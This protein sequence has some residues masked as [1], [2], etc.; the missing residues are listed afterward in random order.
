MGTTDS[1]YEFR[2]SD[3]QI[4]AMRDICA[5]PLGL[6]KHRKTTSLGK[7]LLVGLPNGEG[8]SSLLL[9]AT[10]A[11]V[12]V[13]RRLE[14]QGARWPAFRVTVDAAALSNAVRETIR[15][16]KESDRAG[17]PLPADLRVA[18]PTTRPEIEIRPNLYTEAKLEAEPAEWPNLDPENPTSFSSSAPGYPAWEPIVLKHLDG[19]RV[20]IDGAR[21]D[22]R[23]AAA[24]SKAAERFVVS[25]NPDVLA[26]AAKALGVAKD[27]GLVFEMVGGLDPALIAREEDPPGTFSFGLVMPRRSD[28]VRRVGFVGRVL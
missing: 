12:L 14:L 24:V 6:E 3:D 19:K 22:Q 8:R 15:V 13:V 7:V 16:R 1:V 25:W 26:T 2:L 28:K 20:P 9:V 11:Y 5:I 23:E 4:G 17:V 27:G 21:D 10:D 18:N